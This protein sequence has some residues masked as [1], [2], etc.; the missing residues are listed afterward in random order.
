VRSWSVNEFNGNSASLTMLRR[1][2]RRTKI[3]EMTGADRATAS[4]GK[5]SVQSL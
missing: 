1:I 4:S 2:H 3:A 5:A